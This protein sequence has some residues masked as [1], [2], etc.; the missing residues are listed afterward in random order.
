MPR[1]VYVIYAGGT[2]G[3]RRSPEGYEPAPGLLPEL[4]RE[5]PELRGEGVPQFVVHEFDR[6]LD[7]SNMS[8]RDWNAIGEVIAR[9]LR[10]P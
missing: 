6:L 2:I 8:P 3:M 9:Q 1:S 10:G 4:M 5:M 7:S